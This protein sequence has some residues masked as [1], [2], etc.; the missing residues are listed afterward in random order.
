MFGLPKADEVDA[1]KVYDNLSSGKDV[2]IL[3]VRTPHE[4]SRG[5]IKGSI[6][7]PLQDLPQK[8]GEKIKNKDRT[9][10]VYCLS[11]SRSLS[12]ANLLVKMGYKNVFSMTSGLL[13]WRLRQF[14]LETN[15]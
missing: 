12:A 10:Y 5:F 15:K 9:I 7:I 2:T 4:Y 8:I 3:D 6:N 1:Q 13:S 11:G 14:P